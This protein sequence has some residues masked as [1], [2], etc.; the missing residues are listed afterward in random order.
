VIWSFRIHPASLPPKPWYQTSPLVDRTAKT[1]RE[2]ISPAAIRHIVNIM[3][4]WSTRDE[5]ARCFIGGM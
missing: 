4:R 3:K 2:R 5:D 1:E